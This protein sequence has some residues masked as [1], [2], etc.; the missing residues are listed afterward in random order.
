M[1]YSPRVL[2][3]RSD[4]GAWHEPIE[5]DVLTSCAVNAGVVRRYLRQART[6]DEEGIDKAMKERMARVLYLFEKQGV[7]N[8]VLGSFGTGVFGNRV[9]LVARV[10]QELLVGETARFKFSFDRVEFSILGK[11]TY[12]TFKEILSI[13]VHDVQQK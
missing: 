8:V 9:E 10:W 2:L 4:D 7:R 3:I 12:E 6:S 11:S 1:V 13:S 5:V